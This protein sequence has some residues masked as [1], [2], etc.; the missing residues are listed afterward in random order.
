MAG[1]DTLS[2]RS[3]NRATLARQLLLERSPMRFLDAIDHLVGLQAQNPHDPY[4]GLW[5]RLQGFDPLE[6]SN[7]L[8]QKMVVRAQLMRAT[9]HLVTAAD[10]PA[11]AGATAP[12]LRRVFGSTSYAKSTAAVDREEVVS[13]GVSLLEERPLSRAEL[14]PELAGRW[15][16]ID[17]TSLAMAV[18][19]LSPLI[20]VPPRGL[21]N[22]TGQARWAPAGNWLGQGPAAV[23]DLD[24]LII[25]YLAAFGPAT[26]ADARTWSNLTGLSDVFER[27]RPGLAVLRDE[28]GRELFD[29]PDAPRPDPETPAPVRFLPEYD[30]VLLGHADRSRV[31]VGVHPL[32]WLGNVLV[33]GFLAGQW[34]RTKA[35]GRLL[36]EV[37]ML[38]KQTQARLGE[39]EAEAAAVADLLVPDLDHDVVVT[40]V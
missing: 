28:Q 7:A 1:P 37:E 18:T 22:R 10:Y 27:L 4:I 32:G 19:Y 14:A 13:T 23:P 33:D 31:M 15:P 16:E 40:P 34:K 21:W 11:V 12:V 38:T 30:N 9:I 25:R 17:P 39:V 20:Q 24:R 29:L 3:L 2:R 26:V 5:A 35:K 8:E 36:V 6:L